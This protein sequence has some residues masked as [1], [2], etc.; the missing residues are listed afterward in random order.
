MRLNETNESLATRVLILAAS[1]R[2][3][4]LTSDILTEAKIES[5]IC[6]TVGDLC[7]EFERGAGAI[8]VAEEALFPMGLVEFKVCLKSQEP[9]SDIPIVAITA[10]G[11]VTLAGQE[12]LKALESLRNVTF[13]DRPVRLTTLVSVVRGAIKSRERQYEVRDL[14][15][16]Y[17]KSCEA[18]EEA[19]RAKSTFLANMSHE[20]R[21]P[22]NAIMGFS[23][24]LLDPQTTKQ[25]QEEFIAT[26]RR[27]GSLL[28]QIID[29]ILDL[30]RVEAG[31]IEY[32]SDEVEIYQLMTD[33]ILPLK[34][35]AQQKG[36]EVD[37]LVDVGV[38]ASIETDALRLKQILF[39]IIGNAVKFTAEGGVRIL[40]RYPSAPIPMIEIAVTDTGR[41][42]S[43]EHQQLLFRPFSQG[44]SSTTRKF[45]GTGLGLVLSRRFAEGL[46]GK[47]ELTA[48]EPGLGSTFTISIPAINPKGLYH[49][50]SK[51]PG[52]LNKTQQ[53]PC[54]LNGVNI[55]VVEDAVDNRILIR[56][57]LRSNGAN[58]DLAEN[59]VEGVRKALDQEYDVVL[60]DLQMPIRDGLEATKQLRRLGYN[61]PIVAVSAAAM[62]EERDRALSMGCNDHITKPIN[63]PILLEKVCRYSGKSVH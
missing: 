36:I 39:N 49:N 53:N 19:N 57:I 2:D 44:D 50:E 55:L 47:L 60:M 8:L 10:G 23:Q 34:Q 29:D 61:K 25:D 37:L 27:N 38:P 13:L 45:G 31:K 21:T 46:G 42:I 6:L 1:L 20:I 35:Q 32:Q 22:L 24:L 5:K 62:K 48:S 63:V 14:F 7:Q 54:S 58:V 43:S 51:Q 12:I 56:Q 15:E 41:G 30:S 4:E 33:I 28:I 9:W 18:A 40:L 16:K 52:S 59:G 11:D 17:R 26:I 3:A